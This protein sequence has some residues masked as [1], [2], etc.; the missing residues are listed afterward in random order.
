M[1]ILCNLLWI[2]LA[3]GAL[4]LLFVV[5]EGLFGVLYDNNSTFRGWY[6]SKFPDNNDDDEEDEY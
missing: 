4:C 1:D 3:F 5:T 6:D 2:G